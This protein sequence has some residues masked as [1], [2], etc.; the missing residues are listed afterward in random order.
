[1][2]AAALPV[3]PSRLVP[4]SDIPS[5]AVQQRYSTGWGLG[6]D[7]HLTIVPPELI[8]VTGTPGSGKSQWSLALVANLA[9]VHGL[10]AAILQFEDKPDR[11]RK[12]LLAYARSWK[13][14]EKNGIKEEP[15]VWVDRMFRTIAPAEDA[16]GE[17]DFNLDWLRSTIEEAATRHNCKTVLVD[18]WNEVEHAWRV[19]ETETAYTNQALRELKRIT[20][21]LQIT[22]IVVTHPSKFGGAHKSVNDMSLY[23]IS[24]SAAW[25]NKADHGVIIFREG[26]AAD[27]HVKI[28]KSKDFNTMGF[29]GVVRMKFNA[30]NA[31]FSFVESGS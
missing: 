26:P 3:V 16:D 25:K 14:Q 1:M 21:R 8:V 18:P 30:S 29:P 24:G 17:V 11:N 23:D 27:T 9:R 19:N 6:V 7:Q 5:R 15:S 22:L 13:D 4:F 12:D 2:I 31:S 20:R 28:D 10:K